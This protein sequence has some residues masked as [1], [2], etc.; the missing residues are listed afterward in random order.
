MKLH[1]IDPR[2]AV[3]QKLIDA[4]VQYDQSENILQP[5]RDAC[6]EVL[7]EYKADGTL[8]QNSDLIREFLLEEGLTRFDKHALIVILYEVMDDPS[9]RSV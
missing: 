8:Q 2:F 9:A 3:L 5:R 4:F 7:K 6:R 1:R